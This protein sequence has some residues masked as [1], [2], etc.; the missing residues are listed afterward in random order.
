[1]GEQWDTA[2]FAY[3]LNI[4]TIPSFIFQRDETLW[5]CFSTFLSFSSI[6]IARN[7]S[8]KQTFEFIAQVRRT[9]FS[10]PSPFIPFRGKLYSL[11]LFLFQSIVGQ[12]H[13]CAHNCII[14]VEW[15]KYLATPSMKGLHR[16]ID[17]FSPVKLMRLLQEIYRTQF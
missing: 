6:S 11:V 8:P 13:Q 10:H 7:Q 4:P 9:Y 12:I 1:M 14:M 17:D 2:Y 15:P 5:V 3:Y 16:E